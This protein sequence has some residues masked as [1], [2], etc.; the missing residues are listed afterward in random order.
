VAVTGGGGAASEKDPDGWKALPTSSRWCW[1][2][3]AWNAT[4][5][6]H[7]A[8]SGARFFEQ[9]ERWRQAARDGQCPSRC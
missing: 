9:V 6:A 2:P 5:L 7:A 3:L 8:G 1:R 4:E